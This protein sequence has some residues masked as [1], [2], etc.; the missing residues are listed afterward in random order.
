MNE[1]IDAVALATDLTVAWLANP[2]TCGDDGT[3]AAF[4]TSMHSAIGQLNAAAPIKEPVAPVHRRAVSVRQSLA[5]SDFIISMIDGKPY[6]AL[7]RHMTTNGLSPAG[8]RERYKLRADYPT[9]DTALALMR[10]ALALL[11]QRGEEASLCAIYLQTAI[12]AKT[13]NMPFRWADESGNG[14]G[15]IRG[16]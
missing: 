11:D 4:L 5:D 3:V 6:R 13:G 2:S 1:K 14:H 16:H 10:M 9:P 8:Y 7:R 15:R 12:D